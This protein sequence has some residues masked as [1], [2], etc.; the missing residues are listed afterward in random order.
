MTFHIQDKIK[1][2]ESNYSSKQAAS[3]DLASIP[4]G[5][6][7]KFTNDSFGTRVEFSYGSPFSRKIETLNLGH[8]SDL[9]INAA[10]AKNGVDVEIVG[11]GEW[12]NNGTPGAPYNGI[13]HIKFAGSIFA[14][15][16]KVSEIANFTLDVS[17]NDG[18]DK[19]KVHMLHDIDGMTPEIRFNGGA[20]DDRLDIKTADLLSTLQNLKISGEDGNDSVKLSG[21][22]HV[23]LE[24]DEDQIIGVENLKIKPDIKIHKGSV[25]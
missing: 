9:E 10:Q 15:D 8:I 5:S 23:D 14:D 1:F 17:A 3:V 20:G 13:N 2:G 22:V 7:L 4:K 12:R 11:E 16:F 24:T 18:N 19:V 25:E 21:V 6:K